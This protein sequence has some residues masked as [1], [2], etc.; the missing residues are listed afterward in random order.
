MVKN[1]DESKIKTRLVKLA[2]LI[3]KHNFHYHENDK[4]IISDQ[5]FDNLIRENNELEKKYPHLIL[6]NSP[7]KILGSKPAKKFNKIKHK[8]PMLSLANAFNYKDVEDFISRINKYLN[9]SSDDLEFICEPKIDGL[10]LN[11]NYVNGKL[12]NATT[13]GDGKIGEDVTQNI[14]H[15]QSIPKYLKSNAPKLLEVRGEVYLSKKDFV[16]LNNKL[17]NKEKFSNPRNAAAGSIRQLDSTISKKRP[18]KFIA[19][20]LGYSSKKYSSISEYYD[21]LNTWE[22]FPNN[23][24]KKVSTA[25]EIVNYY[26]T[27]ENKRSSIKYDIDGLVIKVNDITLQE[28]L[29]IVGKN[30]RWAIALK[31]SSEKVKTRIK[32][33]DFQVGRTG[34]ITPVARLQEVNLGGVLISNAT[35]HNFDEIDKKNIGIGDLVEIERAGEV[36]PHVTRLIEKSKIKQNKIKPPNKCPVCNGDT[37]KEKDEAVLRCSNTLNCYAQKLGLIVHFISKKSF[38]IDGFGEKQAKQFFDLKLIKTVLDIFKIQNLKNQIIKLEGWG[39][40]SFNNLVN[41][42]DKSREISFEKFIYSLGIRYIGETNANIIAKEFITLD[43][44]LISSQNTDI[45][46]NVD[47]LGPKAVSSIKNYFSN[48]EN[49]KLIKEL[50]SIIKISKFESIISNNFFSNKSIV[51]SGS[52]TK[53]SRDEAKYKVKNRGAKILSSVSKNTDYLI[54]GE[55]AGSKAEKAKNLGI[56]ILLEDDFLKKIND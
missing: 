53:L 30:P 9:I 27:I 8:K 16:D 6:D 23:L 51:F 48:K 17:D 55:N 45:I 15:I 26:E 37:I 44:F 39:E 11:L 32:F 19:H 28:R 1:L 3:E 25:K 12:D 38:N 40:L 35:L 21:D 2:K 47:G 41:S 29:G 18:L 22:L 52:L 36:I 10:S 20:G 4:P 31:F 13:R 34:A 54:I 49:I 33:I 24:N 5:E 14:L 56:K 50:G 46:S 42:I 7:N 43:N